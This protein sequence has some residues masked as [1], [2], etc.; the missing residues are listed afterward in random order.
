LYV[1]FSGIPRKSYGE[2]PA[3]WDHPVLPDTG[4]CTLP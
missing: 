4:E 1:A 2:S 3:V